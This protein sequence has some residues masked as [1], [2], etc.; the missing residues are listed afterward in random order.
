MVFFKNK[1]FEF[2]ISGILAIL[3]YFLLIHP[4]VEGIRFKHEV[5]WDD[6]TH[7]LWLFND[8]IELDKAL[9]ND[10]N[11]AV[12]GLVRESDLYYIYNL[13]DGSTIHIFEFKDLRTLKINDVDF[14]FYGNFSS[15]TKKSVLILNENL[16]PWP[17][18]TYKYKLPFNNSLKV[19]FNK[20]A[21]IKE[22]K[23][24]VNYKV[25]FGSL[26]T[27]SLSNND[28]EHLV[29]FDFKRTRKVLI[30]FYKIKSK[31]FIILITSKHSLNKN[32]INLL[33]LK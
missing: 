22:I 2:T 28:G 13:N 6:Y 21:P 5:V 32:C 19:S 12:V 31:F 14:N 17:I 3:I 23:K 15:F 27:M 30:A 24:S 20:N 4:I 7:F 16:Q 26:N 9:G 25:Y 8:S 11:L 1:I 10:P 33:N 29:M 18:I